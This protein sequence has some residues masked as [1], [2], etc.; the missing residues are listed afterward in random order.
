M[1][2]DD[3]PFVEPVYSPE[4]VSPHI[5]ARTKKRFRDNRPNESTIHGIHISPSI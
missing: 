1:L 2:D 4:V 3:V 5:N